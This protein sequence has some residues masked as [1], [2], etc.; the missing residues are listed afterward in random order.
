MTRVSIAACVAAFMTLLLPGETRAQQQGLVVHGYLTQAYAQS[1]DVPI[2][3]IGTEG[4]TDYRALA[5]QFRYG[6][7]AN[8]SLV[9][10]FSH[11]R[12]GTSLIQE[13]EPDVALDWAFFQ[14]RWKGNNIRVGRVPMPRGLFNEVRDV[15]V[16]LPFFRASKAFYSE[17]VET[18]DGISAS[19][20]IRLGDSGF[21]F[22]A[23][24]YFGEFTTTLEFVDTDG[25]TVLNDRL[26]K[27]RGAHGVLNTPVAGLRFTGDYVAA[28]Y[29]SGAPFSIWTASGDLT[30]DRWF[31]RAEYELAQTETVEGDPSTDYLAWYAQAGFGLTEKLWLNAQYEFNEITAFGA[32]PSPPLPSPDLA[33]DN[34]RDTAVGVLYKFSP[35]LIFKAEY[36]FF[37][38]YQLDEPTPPLN[39]LTGQAL[40]A[41]ETDYFIISLSAAF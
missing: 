25:L 39:P 37:E 26:R 34:I 28:E 11:R 8:S 36:H 2:Y 24:A 29:D 19:R 18:V 5:L 9:M 21:D 40:P 7:D 23:S 14:R 16:I 22:E 32:L 38:G 6:I 13:L 30:R 27:A 33:Y 20:N 35:L 3:G 17:G 31:A 1:T 15:G 4:T 12:L 41:G 10:Q